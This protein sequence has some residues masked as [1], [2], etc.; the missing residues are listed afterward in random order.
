MYSYVNKTSCKLDGEYFQYIVVAAFATK[1]TKTIQVYSKSTIRS[2]NKTLCVQGKIKAS[3]KNAFVLSAIKCFIFLKLLALC[4]K[5][6]EK[7]NCKKN[8]NS[9]NGIGKF[10][11]C[12]KKYLSL[13]KS[14]QEFVK[15]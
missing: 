2:V 3:E 5:F 4:I 11:N 1:F 9:T 13:S 8:K 6:S 14:C 12:S 10:G 7:K 15:I